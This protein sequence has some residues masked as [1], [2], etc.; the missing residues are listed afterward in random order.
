MPDARDSL[1]ALI[2]LTRDDEPVTRAMAVAALAKTREPAVFAPVLV[3]LFDPV[4]EVRAAAAT[5]LGI[6]GDVRAFEPL[7]QC[8]GDPNPAVGANCVWSLAQIDD[9]RS[10]GVLLA[11]LADA[12]LPAQDAGDAGDAEGAQGAGPQSVA[13]AS[14]GRPVELR[15]AAATA[16]GER[17]SLAGSDISTSEALIDESRKVLLAIASD[18]DADAELRGACVW[19]LGHFPPDDPTT[20][21][22]IDLLA[23][24]FEWVVR[25]AIEALAH[26]GDPSAIAPLDALASGPAGGAAVPADSLRAAEADAAS[27]SH[28]ADIPPADTPRTESIAELAARAADLLRGV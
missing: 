24:S 7:V 23:D 20:A 5:A 3:A 14:A 6:I 8:L 25:Y 26:F 15:R 28:L 13:A 4:D 17:S 1:R 9:P 2:D 21:L 16:I 11:V 10:M 22:C 12:P 18:T 19:T 27:D